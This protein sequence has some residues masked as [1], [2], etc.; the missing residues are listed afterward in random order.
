M[1]YRKV[2]TMNWVRVLVQSGARSGR[3]AKAGTESTNSSSPA[4][5]R[6]WPSATTPASSPAA[7]LVLGRQGRCP[8]SN[9]RRTN[10]PQRDDGPS[11]S[12]RSP[13]LLLL[14]DLFAAADDDSNVRRRLR[15]ATS[16][17]TWL[18]PAAT[19]T[20]WNSA[21]LLLP[22]A[23]A[24]SWASTTWTVSAAPG[25]ANT[26]H[27]RGL[28]KTSKF[29]ASIVGRTRVWTKFSSSLTILDNTLKISYEK[30]KKKFCPKVASVTAW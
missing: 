1:K 15:H 30:K 25:T 11:S 19:A 28:L 29:G 13:R 16:R 8:S 5:S 14:R 22:R 27:T 3:E 26:H 12:L 2:H 23:G 9:R 21:W 18:S 24:L 10:P 6:R 7:A 17:P 4:A 20:W